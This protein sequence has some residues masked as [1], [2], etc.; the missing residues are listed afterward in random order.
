LHPHPADTT[1]QRNF[2]DIEPEK[3]QAI[4]EI[5]NRCGVQTDPGAINPLVRYSMACPAMPTCGLA[6][7]ESERVMPSVLKRIEVL[8]KSVW[9]KSI[10]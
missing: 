4:Q 10:L 6:I 3:Q 1:P 7:T 8:L 2:Y 9:S 5:L